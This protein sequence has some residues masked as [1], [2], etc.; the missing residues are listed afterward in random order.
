LKNLDNNSLKAGHIEW[1][2]DAS[3][4]HAEIKKLEKLNEVFHEV[5]LNSYLG[6]K[7]LAEKE[8]K[9]MPALP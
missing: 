3:S 6:G 9:K 7:E 4:S 2:L 1:V 5:S 8:R